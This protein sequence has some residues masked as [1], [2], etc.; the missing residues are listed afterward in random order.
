M[1]SLLIVDDDTLSRTILNLAMQQEG[2][3][4]M[5]VETAEECLEVAQK[6][7][8][9]MILLDAKMPGMDGFTCCAELRA[10]LR[11]RCPPIV[12][13][14]GLADQT[15]VD[16][17]FAVGA[18]DYVTKP[19]H[20]AVLRHRVRQVLREREL[21]Q[22]LAAI[23]QELANTNKELQQLARIDGLTRLA[24]RRHFEEVLAQEWR[25][26]ARQQKPLSVI[27]CDVDFF[28]QYND[29]YGH[30]AGD[31][32]LQDLSQLLRLSVMRPADMVARYGGEEFIILLPETDEAGLQCVA[33]RIHTRINNAAIPHVG[34]QVADI[35]T[36]SMGTTCTIPNVMDDPRHLLEAADRALY[37]A[38]SK[39]RN[40]SIMQLYHPS[41]V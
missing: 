32:C 39:G 31:F 4:A 7:P 38:K 41:V 1:A 6:K 15:S 21:M 13:I 35:V 3:Q 11:D 27:F 2:H 33:E 36:V 34:S 9:D 24:N 14:T 17:A 28:K 29:V 16:R 5:Q 19:I 8:C 40:Q 18:I 20:M 22:Q 26:L 25:R 37:M 12:M 10:M 23:N 30:L